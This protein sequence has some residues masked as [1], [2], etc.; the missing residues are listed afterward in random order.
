MR[1]LSFFELNASIAK[2]INVP[3]GIGW[4][5]VVDGIEKRGYPMDLIA[6]GQY[7]RDVSTASLLLN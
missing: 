4:S 1:E 2:L 6:A 7:P 5:P 3:G